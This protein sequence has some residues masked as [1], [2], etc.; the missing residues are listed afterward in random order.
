MDGTDW[1]RETIDWDFEA[2]MPMEDVIAEVGIRKSKIYKLVKQERFPPPIKIDSRSFWLRSQITA[3]KK[4]KV[5]ENATLH[6]KEKWINVP[7]KKGE[8][9][10]TKPKKN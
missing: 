10:G 5:K 8:K 9:R 7:H 1:T 6:W 4:A 3:W 2:F